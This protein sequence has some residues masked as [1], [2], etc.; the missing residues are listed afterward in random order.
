MKLSDRIW[1]WSNKKPTNKYSYY[2]AD[3]LIWLAL[4]MIL[5]LLLVS[6]G[7]GAMLFSWDTAL[8]T[9]ALVFLIACNV[10]FDKKRGYIEALHRHY[11][12]QRREKM[13]KIAEEENK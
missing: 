1:L 13:L 8:I 10:V 3:K 6:I 2:A 9:V 4:G 7:Q 5:A 12:K 11:L